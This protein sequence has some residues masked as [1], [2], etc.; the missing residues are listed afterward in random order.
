V[1][2]RVASRLAWSL[3]GLAL[4]F[5]PISL[6]FGSLAFSAPLPGGREPIWV[7]ILIQDVLLLLYGTRGS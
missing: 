4:G 1:R 3:W 5:V 6:F 2:S 7:P